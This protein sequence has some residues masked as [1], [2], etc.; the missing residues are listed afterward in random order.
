MRILIIEDETDLAEAIAMNLRSQ[1]FAVDIASDGVEGLFK[2]LEIDYDLIILDLNLPGLDGFEV[3]QSIRSKKPDMFILMLTARAET[4]DIIRGLNYGA[5]D[6]LTKPFEMKELEARIRTLLRRDLRT[7]EP[8]LQVRDIQLD[9]ATRRVWY[10]EKLIRLSFKE[11]AILHYL[12][13]KPD[14]VISQ[15]EIIDHVWDEDVDLFTVSVRVHIHNL[16]KQFADSKHP[17]I[18]T[19]IGQGYR[20]ISEPESNDE[21]E[22]AKRA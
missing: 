5:D 9:P 14:E 7:R 8:V 6:Y 10:K 20:L 18:E 4:D 13:R 15:A 19:L 12:M 22:Y 17:Y 2:S 1:A 11:Y 3:C 16:R 21:K